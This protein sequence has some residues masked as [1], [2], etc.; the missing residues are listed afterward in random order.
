MTLKPRLSRRQPIEE[1]AT[2]L[3]NEDTTPPVTNIYFGAIHLA[4]V[5]WPGFL[6]ST[7]LTYI[8]LCSQRGELSNRTLRVFPVKFLLRCSAQL[9]RRERVCYLWGILYVDSW[10]FAGVAALETAGDGEKPTRGELLSNRIEA[11]FLRGDAA[12]WCPTGRRP[13]GCRGDGL[14]VVD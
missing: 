12:S 14:R 8:Q 7:G 3:P 9:L 4:R 10:F 1:A 6:P 5:A 13:F 11:S 2:P